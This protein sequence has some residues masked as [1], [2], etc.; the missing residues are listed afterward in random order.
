MPGVCAC[1]AALSQVQRLVL[2][3]S[4][5][6]PDRLAVLAPT[7]SL[8]AAIN[9]GMVACT[10]AAVQSCQ[11]RTRPVCSEPAPWGGLTGVCCRQRC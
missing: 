2:H 5:A 4:K 3:G 6:Q 10:Q 8:A 7:S 9:S 11:E 1:L